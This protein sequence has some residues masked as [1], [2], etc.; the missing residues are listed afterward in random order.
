MSLGEAARRYSELGWALVPL[1]GKM[2]QGYGWQRSLPL[3]PETAEEIWS[4]REGNMGLVLG[5]SGVIDFELDGG[6]EKLYW[7]LANGIEAPCFRTGSGK[8]HILFR[9]PGHL[10]RRTRDGLELRAGA[11]QSVIPPSVHPET[12]K[13][14]EWIS[15]P[16]GYQSLPLPPQA[17]LDFFEEARGGGNAETHWR[18]PL[19][20]GRKLGEGEG[21]HHS[22]MSFLG[23]S[24]NLFDSFDQLLAAAITYAQLT[25][26]PPYSDDEIERRAWDAWNR[27]R[28]VDED[29]SE[30]EKALSIVT[31]DR[32]QMKAVRFL[33]KPFLQRSAFH[34]L[35]G[36]KGAGKGT[37]L[38][39]LAA[40]MTQGFEG[41]AARAVLWI[42]T[43]DSFEIDVKPRFVAQGGD[44]RLLLAVRQSVK[45]PDDLP[46]LEAV[47]REWD[48]GLVVIDP[49]VG[50]VGSVNSNDEGPV[51]AAIGGL[52]AL[53]DE[54]DLAVIGVRHIG[55]GADRN[56]LDR[57]LGN[58]AWVNT[59][60][61]V[62]GMAQDDSRVVTLEVLASNRV[63]AGSS[64]DFQIQEAELPG[65]DGVVTKVSMKGWSNRSMDEVLASRREKGSKIPE[66]KEWLL[67][68][69]QE[70]EDFTK[71]QLTPECIEKFG[72]GKASIDKAATALKEEGLLRFVPGEIDPQTG[73][74][75]A[76]APWKMRLAVP[77]VL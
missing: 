59:P 52:N 57:V 51:V 46:A 20:A 10:T 26:D 25:Q 36:P 1:E 30:A 4:T 64:F 3:P 72:V 47:C 24:V 62:L 28:E 75:K 54:L 70:G 43:E 61:A 60:R 22:L 35:V 42:S 37:V 7:E 33:W 23:K 15:P 55:K 66:V 56:A 50:A 58:V 41:E 14:Y 9:D 34:L 74:K 48:V 69:L 27:Y 63:R 21:R 19:R 2:P 67:E 76:G 38:A 39:W 77:E 5:P 53:A 31:A 16:W 65:L 49:I 11:H 13:P 44:E 71:E 17:L 73:R 18:E 45:L 12:G 32:I 40:Q 68:R 6:D 8:P 29:A